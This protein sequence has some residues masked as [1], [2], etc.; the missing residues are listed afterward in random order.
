MTVLGVVCHTAIYLADAGETFAMQIKQ[1]FFFFF[2]VARSAAENKS[3]GASTL[4]ARFMNLVR[5]FSVCPR[6]S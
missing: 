5:E 1:L 3:C 6:T 2:I 4:S